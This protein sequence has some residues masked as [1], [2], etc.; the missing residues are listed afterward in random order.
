MKRIVKR[1]YDQTKSED[2]FIERCKNELETLTLYQFGTDRGHNNAIRRDRWMDES[3]L[4]HW[5]Q[6]KSAACA[7]PHAVRD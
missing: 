2:E 5:Y 4:R 3:E 7:A 1:L 6:M